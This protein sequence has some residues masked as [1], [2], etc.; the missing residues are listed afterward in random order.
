MEKNSC[1]SLKVYI[2]SYLMWTSLLISTPQPTLP[3]PSS[4]FSQSWYLGTWTMQF[5]IQPG[6]LLRIKQVTVNYN[7]QDKRYLLL[8]SHSVMSNS[9]TPWTAANQTSLP[10]TISQSLFKLM[11]T[12]LV[13][14]FNRLF[15]CHPHLLLPSIFPSIRVYSNN[16]ALHIRW[17]KYCSFIFSIS[18]EWILRVDFL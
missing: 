9:V 8:F 10:F 3:P 5:T 12:E 17:P 11:S 1:W 7:H 14:L 2:R 16:S 6:T 13:M 4:A 18:P 15:L